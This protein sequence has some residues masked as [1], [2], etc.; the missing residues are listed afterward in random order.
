MPLLAPD[1]ETVKKLLRAHYGVY[2]HGAVEVCH[3]TKKALRGE[4]TCYKNRFYGIET[5]RCMEFTPTSVYCENRCIYCWRPV[6]FY[7]MLRMP[8]EMVAEPEELVE[9]LIKERR[10][11]LIGFL[12]N[13]KAD[14]R[15]VMESLEPTHY[16]ISLSGEPTMYP[17]LPQLISY[18]KRREGTK[19]VFL[20]T[21]G[22]EP[23][24]LRRLKGE[25]LPTQLYLSMTGYDEESYGRSSRPMYR[26]GWERW[27]ESLDLLPKADTRTVIRLT[28]MRGLNDGDVDKAARL[29]MRGDPHFVEVKSYMHIG[30]S[31]SRLNRGHMLEFEEVKRYS[32][33]LLSKL[34]GFEF[35]DEA[36]ESRIVVLRNTRRKAERWI[37]P[38]REGQVSIA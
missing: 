21:N 3:W 36:R 1:Q 2:L 26:D 24:M 16:A 27:L 25:S 4:G 15:L 38:R 29:I 5:H 9:G 32:D 17:K 10:R 28:I 14:R 34:E 31:L 37:L 18:L 7:R 35:M 30:A 11:L 20:V 33:L 6:E 19:S 23:E 8:E 22:Q 12:G 13:E